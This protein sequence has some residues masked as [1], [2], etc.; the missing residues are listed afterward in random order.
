[1][2]D[3]A[4]EKW[5]SECSQ[6]AG[7]AFIL[8]KSQCKTRRI[9]QR[10]FFLQPRPTLQISGIFLVLTGVGLVFIIRVACAVIKVGDSRVEN[11][12]EV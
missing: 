6:V 5:A 2:I 11:A 12:V 1:M 7:S 10:I 3:L 4:E 8:R 9:L